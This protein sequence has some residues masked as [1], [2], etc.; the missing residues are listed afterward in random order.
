VSRILRV[1]LTP[2][3]TSTDS[4]ATT[5]NQTPVAGA[6]VGGKTD[7]ANQW[8]ASIDGQ[9]LE[10]YKAITSFRDV[11]EGQKWVA[12]GAANYATTD[13][14]HPSTAIHTAAAAELRSAVVALRTVP[15]AGGL[16]DAIMASYTARIAAA[17]GTISA[18]DLAAVRALALAYVL[19]GCTDADT[20]VYPFCGNELAAALV[21]LLRCGGPDVGTGANLVGGDYFRATGLTG[22]GTSKRVETGVGQNAWPASSRHLAAYVRAHASSTSRT[23]LGSIGASNTNPLIIGTSS[24][25]GQFRYAPGA[26]VGNLVTL[27]A[28][29]TG[30][31][32]GTGNTTTP[33]LNA[34]LY[35]GGT[36][37]A[38]ATISAATPGSQALNILCSNTNGSPSG[39]ADCSLGGISAGNALL[40]RQIADLTTAWNAY[41]TAMGR[42]V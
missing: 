38:S 3:T 24:S 22:N 34:R 39:Y 21:P 27:A 9:E 14:I 4:W 23:Y 33:S 41:C 20:L 13:G 32:V 30:L 25:A 7:L 18:A 15:T 6:T 8:F 36:E 17:G 40:P 42:G 2:R 35:A 12:T 28:L 26:S 31:I 16:L 37:Q 1:Q 10:D 19:Q 5:A 11:D 29:P